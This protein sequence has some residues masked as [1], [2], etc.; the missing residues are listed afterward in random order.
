MACYRGASAKSIHHP[1]LH[2]K[3]IQQRAGNNRSWNLF[4]HANGIGKSLW[5]LQ[6]V[7]ALSRSGNC[8]SSC[9]VSFWADWHSSHQIS[10]SVQPQIQKFLILWSLMANLHWKHDV[11][12]TTWA[13]SHPRHCNVAFRS[14]FGCPPSGGPRMLVIHSIHILY[15]SWCLRSCLVFRQTAGFV[16]KI[17]LFALGLNGLQTE[18]PKWLKQRMSME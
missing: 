4:A 5:K 18:G 10:G 17:P 3:T 7:A 8:K 12:W 16:A 1:S 11:N 15:P 6:H 13:K 14:C 9:Q 2:Y